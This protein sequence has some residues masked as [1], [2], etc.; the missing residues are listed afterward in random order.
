MGPADNSRL[1]SFQRF[2]RERKGSRQCGY[3]LKDT[4]SGA[5]GEQAGAK[6]Q[7]QEGE[8]PRRRAPSGTAEEAHPRPH[9]TAEPRG[10]GSWSFRKPVCP[11][12]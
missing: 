8:G 12:C 7:G 5:T 11:P 2:E 3:K 10:A 4:E 6:Q 1:D 9:L